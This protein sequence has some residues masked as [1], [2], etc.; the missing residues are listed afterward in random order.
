MSYLG[1]GHMP[2]SL[3]I[4]CLGEA[5]SLILFAGDVYACQC[6]YIV[7]VCVC[8]CVRACVRAC[9]HVCVTNYNGCRIF[10]LMGECSDRE[11]MA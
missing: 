7:C 1:D 5:E 4:S 9:V 3:L 10:V 11:C 2:A 6:L 8:V